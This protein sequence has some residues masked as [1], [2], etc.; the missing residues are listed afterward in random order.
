VESLPTGLII[1]LQGTINGKSEGY[2]FCEKTFINRN[3]LTNPII[4]ND[5]GDYGYISFEMIDNTIREVNEKRGSKSYSKKC[6]ATD[7]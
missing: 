2:L 1:S 5:A 3:V 6:L 7:K 4:K